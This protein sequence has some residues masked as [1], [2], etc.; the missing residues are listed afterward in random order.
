MASSTHISADPLAWTE[1]ALGHHRWARRAIIL[2]LADFHLPGWFILLL[3]GVL[4]FV[5]Y[6]GGCLFPLAELLGGRKA[7]ILKCRGL[8]AW[9]GAEAGST[10]ADDM[11]AV[12]SAATTL[13]SQS[14]PA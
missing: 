2:L 3:L 7:T 13:A 5:A 4:T 1:E 14:K 9:H 11:V 10:L 6:V 8:L 12:G